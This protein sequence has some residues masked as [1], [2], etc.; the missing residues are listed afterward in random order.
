MQAALN[1]PE[2]AQVMA[3]VDIVTAVKPQ[4]SIVKPL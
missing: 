4:R 3:D 2:T 1:S